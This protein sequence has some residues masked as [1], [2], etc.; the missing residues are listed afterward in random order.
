[1]EM[2]LYVIVKEREKPRL[3]VSRGH[4]IAQ[5]NRLLGG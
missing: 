5:G 2:L 4:A 3:A 1:M